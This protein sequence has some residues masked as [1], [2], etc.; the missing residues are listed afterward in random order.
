MSKRA[1]GVTTSKFVHV[2]MTR[3]RVVWCTWGITL[4]QDA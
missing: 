3:E 2:G 1:Q 4:F